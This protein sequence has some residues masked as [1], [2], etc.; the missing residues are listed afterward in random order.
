MRW[1]LKKLFFIYWSAYLS[2]QVINES[3]NVNIFFL[4]DFWLDLSFSDCLSVSFEFFID[5]FLECFIP[6]VVELESLRNEELFFGN[7]FLSV[8]HFLSSLLNWLDGRNSSLIGQSFDWFLS[9]NEDAL[10]GVE[11]SFV[12]YGLHFHCLKFQLNEG[13]KSLKKLN[14]EIAAIIFDL[15]RHSYL[16]IWSIILLLSVNFRGDEL[17]ANSADVILEGIFVVSDLFLGSSWG[18]L[19]RCACRGGF[20]L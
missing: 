17:R 4:L 11:D 13:R 9:V 15:S 12:R 10:D 2:S 16:S 18:W 8:L 1:K 3:I 19:C 5:G 14:E 20:F 7:F 6:A